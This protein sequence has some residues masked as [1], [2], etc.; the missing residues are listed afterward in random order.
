M[1]TLGWPFDTSQAIWR[2]IMGGV[3]DRYP[4]L[5]IV[6]HHMG[7]MFPY[8]SRRIE[9]RFNRNYRNEL[10]HD[11]SFYLRNFYGDTATDGT[12]A[13]YPC[14]YAFF[15]AD[16]LMYGSDYPFGAEAGEDVIRENLNGIRTLDVPPDE[17][18]KIL[19]GNAKKLL[20]IG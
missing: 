13:A 11:L 6:T 17:M 18:E 14:G 10:G 2:I 15:G 1:Q 3:L 16:R 4:A 20:K 8:F 9:G 19:G 7:A 12:T 5:K